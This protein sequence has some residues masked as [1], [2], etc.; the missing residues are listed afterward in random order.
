MTRGGCAP[1]MPPSF[2]VEAYDTG[3]PA[4]RAMALEFP[5]DDATLASSTGTSVQFM[6]GLWFLVAPVYRPLEESKARDGIYLPEGDWVDYW[7]W[8]SIMS[9]PITVD[10]YEAPLERLPMFVR[11]GAIVPQWPDMLYHGEKPVDPLTLEAFP[12]GTTSFELYE[13]DGRRDPAGAQKLRF[14]QDA[15][16]VHCRCEST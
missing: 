9:G 10:G 11:A 7:D 6:L 4:V 15:C 12:S 8:S 1:Q 13:D 3:F 2:E 14:C 16:H 5:N